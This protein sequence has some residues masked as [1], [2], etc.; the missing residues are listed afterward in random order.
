MVKYFKTLQCLWADSLQPAQPS[1]SFSLNQPTPPVSK[2]SPVVPTQPTA[3]I[4]PNP[5]PNRKG[6]PV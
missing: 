2:R 4:G 1:S 5:I 6:D 3:A